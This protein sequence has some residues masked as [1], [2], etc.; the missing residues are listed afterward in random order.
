MSF[1][2]AEDKW[3]PVFSEGVSKKMSLYE[4]FESLPSIKDI[5]GT[6]VEEIAIFRLLLCITQAALKGPANEEN[7]SSCKDKIQE[8]VLDYLKKWKDRFD[9]FGSKPFLQITDLKPIKNRK[10][11][12][13]FFK[14]A[15]GQNHTLFDFSARDNNSEVYEMNEVALALTVYQQ[16]A[17]CGLLKTENKYPPPLGIGS[18]YGAI[19][20]NILLS[21]LKGNNLLE[22]LYLNLIPKDKIESYPI[23]FGKPVWELNL[24]TSDIISSQGCEKSY[25][26]NLVPLTRSILL[27]ENSDKCTIAGGL[28]ISEAKGNNYYPSYCDPMGTI[29][30]R[31]KE[32]RTAD[33]PKNLYLPI[34]LDKAPWRELHSILN[35]LKIGNTGEE[36]GPWALSHIKG[37]NIKNYESES[38]FLWTGGLSCSKARIIDNCSW[39]YEIELSSI[40]NQFAEAYKGKIEAADKISQRIYRAAAIYFNIAKKKKKKPLFLKRLV[41]SACRTFWASLESKKDKLILDINEYAK[42]NKT[43]NE[44]SIKWWDRLVKREAVAAF[45]KACEQSV[46]TNPII[47][48]KALSSIERGDDNE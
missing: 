7:W 14:R 46:I 11:K 25:L 12:V 47:F 26:Y 42:A 3:I 31:K 1:N 5:L 39:N 4:I 16:F 43:I 30:T 35:S 38:V 36:S 19:P 37:A 21:I 24:K 48:V 22:T 13:L 33:K 27:E 2:L 15:T 20:V 28:H 23:K 8:T 40:T 18:D 17:P 10:L 32:N 45:K 9:L 44:D 41:Q 29:I 34:S 6:P